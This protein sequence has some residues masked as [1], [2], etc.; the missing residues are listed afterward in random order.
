MSRRPRE[1]SSTGYYHVMQRGAGKQILF[2]DETD[3]QR[4]MD[5]LVECKNEIGFSL[6]AYCLMNNHVH[7]LIKTNQLRDL[8]KAMSRIGT[9]YAAYYNVR[10][11]HVGNVFQGRF[12]S[13]PIN[14]EE[15][16]LECVKYIHNNPVK[17]NFGRIDDYAWSSYNEYLGDGAVADTGEIMAL[18]GSRTMFEEFHK[19]EGKIEFDECDVAAST[20]EDGLRI[21]RD[22]FNN[23][24]E[25]PMIVKMLGKKSRDIV[26]KE[27]KKQGLTNHQIEL[28]TGISR[29]LVRRI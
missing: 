19:K 27:M 13:S 6:P 5:K 14:D 10:Y 26:I 24:F 7:L 3:Y 4:Y 11:D 25:S 2:E 1:E 9:S 23:E 12:L 22:Y 15:Y 28:I 16:L 29:D 18:F 20:C 17:A 8:S 21:V